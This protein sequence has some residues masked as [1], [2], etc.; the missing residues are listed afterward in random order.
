MKPETVTV[1]LA[2]RSYAI[3]MGS[4]LLGMPSELKAAIHGPDVLVVS[5]DTV[6]PLYADKVLTSLGDKHAELHCL[7][8]GEAHKTL[9]SVSG[10]YDKLVAMRANRDTTII[11]LGGGVVGDMAGFAAATY[12]RGVQFIQLPTTLLSQ[13]DSSVGGKTA[14]NHAAGK[15]LIGAFHQP[16]LVL[17]DIDTLSTLSDRE[18]SAGLAEV[19]K[20]GLINDAK[21]F[22]WLEAN[23]SALRA[24]EPAPLVAA[25]K[26]SCQKKAAVVKADEREK[27]QRALLNLGH[28]F[29]HAIEAVSGYGEHL[30]GEAVA[31]GMVMAARASR[32]PA[33]SVERIE[34]L[35]A[36]A[37][38]PVQPPKLGADALWSAMQLDK[39]VSDGKVRLVLLNDIGDTFV[40]SDYD[41]GAVHQALAAA[42]A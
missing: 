8:D 3:R 12:Q 30:H 20:Y 31:M 7:K 21:F 14:V 40:S 17:I 22:A 28:T 34:A 6:A 38:L 36:D 29:G 16:A 24:R 4:G 42:N 32:L 35:L 26:R 15:N 27:G 1:D 9:E 41:E 37:G 2:E 18:L 19:I 11:A 39:K 5:N 10:I 25:I 33:A 23:M 13:V